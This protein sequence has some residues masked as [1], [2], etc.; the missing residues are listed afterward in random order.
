MEGVAGFVNHRLQVALQ[1]GGVHEDERLALAVA[2]LL[3]AA[4]RLALTRFE[5]EAVGV[6]IESKILPSPPSMFV[7]QARGLG[8]QVIGFS[9]G[10]RAGPALGVDSQVPRPELSDLT[11]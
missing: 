3:V 8:D 11:P 6:R 9:N 7:E 5:I 2:I 1:A 10:R 4:R